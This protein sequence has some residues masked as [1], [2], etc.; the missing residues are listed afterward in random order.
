[1]TEIWT[2]NNVQILLKYFFSGFS[3]DHG[4]PIQ[5]SVNV[6]N[7]TT[8]ISNYL[9]V[10]GRQ[11]AICTIHLLKT[12]HLRFSVVKKPHFKW[13]STFSE[14]QGNSS[15]RVVFFFFFEPMLLSEFLSQNSSN[16]PY[17]GITAW[18]LLL[19]PSIFLQ[20]PQ[21]VFIPLI[22]YMGGGEFCNLGCLSGPYK[23]KMGGGSEIMQ[24]LRHV[25][26]RFQSFPGR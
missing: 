24:L 3:K 20:S 26:K 15:L 5:Y 25:V 19:V 7:K 23:V 10:I 13:Y 2:I 8:I 14:E 17:H 18:W 4:A 11:K 6:S 21:L 12:N 16:T 22:Q 1:M 9:K